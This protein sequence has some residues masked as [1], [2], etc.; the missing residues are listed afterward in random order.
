MSI[1]ITSF[2]CGQAQTIV[3]MHAIDGDA[4]A[5]EDNLT[6]LVAMK[7]VNK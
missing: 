7:V 3:C 1:L 4:H 2:V 5:D 6:Y